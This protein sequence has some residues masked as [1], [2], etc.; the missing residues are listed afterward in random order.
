MYCHMAEEYSLEKGYELPP[1]TDHPRLPY[2]GESGCILAPY[3]RP[4][5]AVHVCSINGL[6]FD[7]KDPKF[8]ADYFELREKIEAIEMSKYE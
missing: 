3:M 6:G 5:C 7:P 2:M 1:K 8:T 4:I